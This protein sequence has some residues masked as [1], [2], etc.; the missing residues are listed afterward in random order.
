[1]IKTIFEPYCENCPDFFA[2]SDTIHCTNMK[3][4]DDNIEEITVIQCTDRDQ[5]ARLIERYSRLKQASE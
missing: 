2:T 4:A 1:M 5:C 3:D